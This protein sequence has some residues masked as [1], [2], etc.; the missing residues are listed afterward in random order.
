METLQS[1]KNAHQMIM[2]LRRKVMLYLKVGDT[3]KV[4]R[5]Q[6]K[7]DIIL[8]MYI[9]NDVESMV[10]VDTSAL[11]VDKPAY[12]SVHHE[13]LTDEYVGF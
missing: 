10:L 13:S 2:S 8:A 1:L 11:V 4:R 6:E 3:Q 12:H 5:Y 7:I 9:T